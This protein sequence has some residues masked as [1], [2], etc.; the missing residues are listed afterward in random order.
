M[1]SGR[2]GGI[3]AAFGGPLPAAASFLGLTDDQVLKIAQS[4]MMSAQALPL[5]AARVRQW[6]RFDD[7]MSEL[8]GRGLRHVLAKLRERDEAAGQTSDGQA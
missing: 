1:T 4:A 6:A 8:A 5:G 7:A 2:Q 3:P